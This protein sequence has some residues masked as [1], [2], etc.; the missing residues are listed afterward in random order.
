MADEFTDRQPKFVDQAVKEVMT[1][2]M[3]PESEAVVEEVAVNRRSRPRPSWGLS[4][5]PDD[6]EMARTQK[7]AEM[8]EAQAKKA[9]ADKAEAAKAERSRQLQAERLERQ[10][11]MS[12]KIALTQLKQLYYGRVVDQVRMKKRD[13]HNERMGI[14]KQASMF[15][16]LAHD[17]AK[18]IKVLKDELETARSQKSKAENSA[19]IMQSKAD[20]ARLAAVGL[21]VSRQFKQGQ[22]AAKSDAETFQA[23]AYRQKRLAQ[24]AYEIIRIS[25]DLIEQEE[26]KVRICE[27]Q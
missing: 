10:K 20:G 4:P 16:H 8:R 17:A 15:Q 19:S 13:L 23:E 12:R 24:A 22:T 14:E 1:W 26:E 27:S 3:T 9:S 21:S 7:E 25:L 11:A 6:P 2:F 18:M 5:N